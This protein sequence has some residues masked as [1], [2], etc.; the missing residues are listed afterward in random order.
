VL[1]LTAIT[2]GFSANNDSQLSQLVSITASDVRLHDVIERLTQLTGVDIRCGKNN[3]DWQVRDIPVIVCV[4]DMPLGNLLRLIV[5]S[6]HLA[7]S[8][9]HTD[10]GKIICRIFRDKKCQDDL[11]AEWRAQWDIVSW[12]WN[13][14]VALGKHPDLDKLD[15]GGQFASQNKALAKLV[16]TLPP[17]TL[18]RLYNGE[19]IYLTTKSAPNAS[20]IIGL[21]KTI[22]DKPDHGF[23]SKS[24]DSKTGIVNL[25]TDAETAPLPEQ[26]DAAIVKIKAINRCYGID[27]SI[28]PIIKGY[29]VIKRSF[30]LQ[31]LITALKYQELLGIDLSTRPKPFFNNPEFKI[32]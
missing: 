4:K 3:K 11:D 30:G 14:L 12:D 31:Y 20:A 16:A 1:F 28:F 5:D 21:Y 13:A 29:T 7:Y 2:S 18:N 27:I 32:W 15:V 6:T 9:T 24:E 26:I 19:E 22:W 25:N 10:D 23:N 8:V 17:D